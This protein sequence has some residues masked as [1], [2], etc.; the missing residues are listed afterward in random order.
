MTPYNIVI[1]LFKQVLLLF[2]FFTIS[3]S[4]Y[5]QLGPGG[6]S[7]ETP[8]TQAP[9]QSDLRLWLDASTLTTL[10]DGDPV[11][12]W[13][14]ISYSAVNDKG[15]RQSSD[16]F[17][18]P[19]FRD[20]PSAAINGYPVVTFE[21]GR[22]LKVN[23]SSD[24]NTSITTTY[25]QTMIFAFRT[26]E[27]VT[28]RQILWEEGGGWRGMN[29]FIYNGE[30]Y[31]GAYDKQVDNDPGPNVPAFGYNYVKSPIQ[32]NTT[33]VLSHIFSA[34]TNNTLNGYVNGYQNGSYF[35]TLINGG[36][37]NGGIG[38]VYRH[39]DAIGIGAVNSDSFNEH[40]PINNQTGLYSFRG[41]L[42]EICYYNKLLN[43]AER[44]IVENYL[45]AKYYANIIVNDKYAHQADYGRDV[46][47]IGQTS[48]SPATRHSVSQGRNPFEISPFNSGISFNT[49][50]EFLFV[51]SNGL[52]L[53]LT[54]DNVPNDPGSTKRTER[55]WRFDESGDLS[56]VKFRFHIS[57]LPPLP[58]GFSKHILI[59]DNTSPN[60]PSFTT[61]NSTTYELADAGGGFY[62]AKVNV[63][64]NSFMTIG[65]LKPQVSFANSEAFAVEGDPA[66]DSTVYVNKVY[67]RLNYIPTSLVKI[68]FSFTDGT[69]TR[70]TDY[71]YLNSDVSNGVTF[72]PGVQQVP[73]RIWV[74]NDIVLEDNPSTE[75]FYINLEIGSNT[76]TGVGMGTPSQHTFTIYD[77]DPPPKLSFA[78]STSQALEGVGSHSID[79]V[80]TGSTAGTASA[81]VKINLG[82]STTAIANEDYTYPVYK[83]VVF[84]PGESIKSVTVDILDDDI[85]EVNEFI[86]FQLYYIAGAGSEASSILFHTVE[87]LD[88]DPPPTIEFTSVT[89]QNYETNGTPLIL[90]ELDKPS[91]KPISVSY[92]KTEL[93]TTAASYGP[94]YE[95]TFPATIIIPPGD[96][97]GYPI[98]FFVQQD[99]IAEDDETVEFE[100]TGASNANVGTNTRHV[101]TIKDYSTFEW[102]GAAGVG[103]DSDNIFW[104]DINRQSGS[105]NSSLQILTNFSPQN[106]D[107]YQNTEGRRANIQTTSNLINGK[108]TMNFDGG[109]M[110]KISNSGLINIAPYVVNKSYFMVIKTGVS[111]NGWHT[112]YKQGGG[113][114]GL[115]IYIQDGSLYFHAWNN[116]NDGSESP[117]G[118][119][120]GPARYAR[121]DGL[122]PNTAYVVECLFDKDATNK[123]RV[124]VN[125]E[126]GQRTET[127]SCGRI[128]SHSGA[129]SLGGADG[130]AR[131]H[132]NSS[133]SGRYFKGYLAEMIHFSDAPVNETRRKILE[134]YLSGKYNIP[135]NTG[136]LVELNTGLDND[137]AGI[138][139]LNASTVDTHTDSQGSSILRIKTPSII[140]NNSFAFWGHNNV[141]LSEIW[142][143]SNASLPNG[144][145]ERSGRVW[146]FSKTGS[147]DG[148]QI[149]IRFNTALNAADFGVNDL[150][151]L[152]HGNP[153]AQNF[154]GARIIN[155]SEIM[156]GY[157]ARFNNVSIGDG[158][159]I[160]LANA[161]SITP[162]PIELL[163]FEASASGSLVN[164]NWITSTEIN[165][166]FFEIQRADADLKF[167]TIAVVNGAGTSNR[168]LFYSEIDREPLQ[169]MNYYRLKQIDYDGVYEYSD[170]V[171]VLF[172]KEQTAIDNFDFIVY[173]NPT[174][175][176]NQINIIS[177]SKMGDS[178]EW[179]VHITSTTGSVLLKLKYEA[180]NA[181]QTINLPSRISSGAYLITLSNNQFTKSQKIIV[182]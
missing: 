68:D 28:S 113:S 12:I 26:S 23:S 79:I 85:D 115:A 92:T 171:S 82:T 21:D 157:V 69:A 140:T 6:V 5:S 172:D 144:V 174:K 138:G 47:G 159:F 76:T 164:L 181:Y 77:N 67:A 50:N 175:G 167:E 74:K 42:A 122:L 93:L 121:Y 111:V 108:K 142:P 135:L 116:P 154:N 150:K 1:Q 38:G 44:I 45:G 51:G 104:L 99:G 148:F 133:T 169:G 59:F 126:L 161:S 75:S 7:N 90:I 125:G 65:V 132:D 180:K 176:D 34:P 160:A 73:I 112:I 25:E 156:S 62:E 95:L 105:H 107:I 86:K 84:A 103:K 20:D 3:P 4:S 40:G 64:D 153:D 53:T 37:Y 124:Y 151:L 87:I 27:D 88:D 118:S 39:P 137:I 129:I 147:I 177:N 54:E 41:R 106:I 63:I 134:N 130:D 31:L 152:I 78:Q 35:G 24:L 70:S 17:L 72:P 32:P 48:N 101:Y 18:P 141:A 158:E 100:I 178:T 66:P 128:Y 149:L 179:Q 114:R 81:R 43:D 14:D 36:Q 119:G 143:W 10:A 94:D 127:G 52:P 145:V 165:N 11:D 57:D 155:A 2:L 110:Y 30:I 61:S 117:W 168:M 19:Y 123:L 80:R 22:M 102:K 173:P 49:S 9:T 58:A 131:Y 8:N 162:L 16:N 15:F 29:A 83:T 97:L 163:S 136:Q 56:F 166:E 89:S 120:F 60:F 46:I 55:I 96:T 13:N 170:V 33:Y 98:N 146:H 109:D 139:Q 182:N 71:G 91:S